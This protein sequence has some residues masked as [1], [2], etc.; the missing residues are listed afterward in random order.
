MGP[1]RLGL[2]HE[3]VPGAS[4]IGVLTNPNFPT[5]VR[6]LQDVEEAA[7]TI[8]QR[9]VISNAS[10]DEELDAAFVSLVQEHVGALDNRSE[11]FA[12]PSIPGAGVPL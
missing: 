4:L 6:E 7:R 11:H 3:L 5:A 1:K 10:H 12:P 8:G 2:L 9:L